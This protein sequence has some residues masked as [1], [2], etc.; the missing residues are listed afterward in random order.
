MPTRVFT[1]EEKSQI[2]LIMLEAG[3]PLL[4]KY[5]MTHTTISRITESAGIAK[6]TF[7]H[8]WKNKEE[9]MADLI[10]YHRQKMIPV[11]I[12]DDVLKGKRK[13]GE[14]DARK[15]LH[16]VVDEEISIYPHLT[17]EDEAKLFKNTD[18][19]E[20]D[21]EKESAITGELLRHLDNVRKDVNLPLI[22]NMTKLLVI[23]S[24]SRA[25][26]HEAVYKE[27]IDTLVD[28]ILNLVFERG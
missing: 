24:E 7:Y 20:P 3:F 16:A 26:L 6:G 18:T 5:G 13:L 10:L 23:A 14:E 19:F 25:E 8:F 1:E 27:T 21:I 9:Y 17:L 28:T 12:S 22:A 15:Y 11:L 2:K 4:K